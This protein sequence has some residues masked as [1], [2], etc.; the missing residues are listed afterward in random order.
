MAEFDK[1]TTTANR[2]VMDRMTDRLRHLNILKQAVFFGRRVRTGAI[3]SY[4]NISTINPPGKRFSLDTRNA[5]P[6]P[7]EAVDY[8]LLQQYMR[9]VRL[10]SND[11]VFDV[12]CGMGRVL[13]LFARRDVRKCI[14]IEFDRELAQIA[15]SNS[16]SLRGRRAPV[17]IRCCD[18]IEAD[19]SEGTV[20]WMFNP[21]GEATMRQVLSRIQQ[22]LEKSPRRVQLAYI[23]PKHEDLV[24]ELKTFACIA[25]EQS[26]FFR[27]YGASYW[28]NDPRP[29]RE[30]GR[31]G[32]LPASEG[33]H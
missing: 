12:G 25:R 15:V 4:L 10:T 22:S 27:T 28:T 26:P 7:Y 17:E 3:E 20:Y 24:V 1:S 33:I 21:F 13:C 16:R 11:V 18:A 2:T 31:T 30:P 5:D 29:V 14:G 23:N 8:V 32:N 19:Y 9:P 6:V